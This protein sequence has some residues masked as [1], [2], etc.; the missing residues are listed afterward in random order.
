MPLCPSTVSGV[1]AMLGIHAVDYVSLS[2][3]LIY[4]LFVLFQKC[5]RRQGFKGV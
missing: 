5:Y 2:V 4:Q 1:T 3:A